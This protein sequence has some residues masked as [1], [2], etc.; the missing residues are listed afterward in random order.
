MAL[1]NLKPNEVVKLP[2]PQQL[3][4]QDGQ[5]ENCEVLAKVPD[6]IPNLAKY[7]HENSLPEPIFLTNDF[8]TYQEVIAQVGKLEFV[9]KGKLQ[10]ATRAA[11]YGL[12]NKIQKLEWEELDMIRTEASL[13]NATGKIPLL[14]LVYSLSFD[15]MI[16]CIFKIFNYLIRGKNALM[17]EA[18][19]FRHPF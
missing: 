7:C 9:V 4:N 18:L 12:L 11:S 15:F 10:D 14:I 19:K 8:G 1:M 16:G 6:A 5:K 3:S 13:S 2:L 17:S